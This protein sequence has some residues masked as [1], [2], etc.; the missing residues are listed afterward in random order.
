[1]NILTSKININIKGKHIKR[2]VM[3]IIKE[4]IELL[5]IKYISD[6][7]VNIKV[8]KYDYERL[9]ELK[10]IYEIT[11]INYYGLIRI[12]K[13]L[14]FNKILLISI[15]CGFV[16]LIILSNMIFSVEVI[17]N[18]PQ[19]RT[20]LLNELANYNIKKR[21]FVKNYD[22]IEK[23]KEG[24]LKKH[25]NKIEWLE[26]ENIGTKYIVRVEERKIIDTEK[27]KE[28]QHVVANKTAVIRKVTSSSGVVIRNVEDYVKPGDIV[29]SGQITDGNMVRA[30]GT[31]YGEVWYETSISFPF[32]YHEV[33]YTGKKKS[34]YAFQF[35]N[36]YFTLDFNKYKTKKVTNQNILKHL[37]LPIGLV[38]QTQ[39]ET[40]VIDKIYTIEQ[41]IDA[42]ILVGRKKIEDKLNDN[43][44]IIDEKQLKVNVKDS[45][46]EVDIFYAVYENI[47]GYQPIIEEEEED[48]K[49]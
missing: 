1:M 42:A 25:R 16:L 20:I 21:S 30:E 35:L 48:A 11:I 33:I 29:I 19:V 4:K 44:Y 15:F 23:V 46:I 49:K 13:G 8:Y 41:A 14:L 18:S 34:L 43:E 40:N 7:E 5:N 36:N 24:I 39:V 10:S 3:R 31:I 27:N 32:Q 26:I 28:P 45:K 9:L 2:F 37:Y 47:T 38:K 12:K 17:H 22:Y 6:S